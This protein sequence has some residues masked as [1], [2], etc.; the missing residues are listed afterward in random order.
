[1]LSLFLINTA[2]SPYRGNGL[3]SV[4]MHRSPHGQPTNIGCIPALVL[5]L[6]WAKEYIM[7]I[8]MS[9]YNFV[10]GRVAINQIR[11]GQ[12]L[13][14]GNYAYNTLV[15]IQWR[16]S[17][18]RFCALAIT[19][20]FTYK[21][22]WYGKRVGLSHSFEYRIYGLQPDIWWS[23]S[24][25]EKL[26]MRKSRLALPR[27]STCGGVTDDWGWCDCCFKKLGNDY[28]W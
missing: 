2:F 5:L 28:I 12:F 21:Y 10:L 22:D 23:L 11:I 6:S 1:M 18:R 15:S 26:A 16:S 14:Y 19:L 4:L 25:E 20:D 13:V 3:R 7:N 27:C 9:I 17:K 24:L 8:L